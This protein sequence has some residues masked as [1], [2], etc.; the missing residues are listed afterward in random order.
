M[1]TTTYICDICK[2]SVSSDDLISFE[3]ALI[4]SVAFSDSRNLSYSNK[5]VHKDI[6]KG[7]LEKFGFDITKHEN[8]EDRE[9][10]QSK[11]AKTLESK[12]VDLLEDL[13]VAFVE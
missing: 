13:G 9:S 8:R 7:C 2:Q 12:F 1:K 10:M 6:C 3:A 11:N 5:S 4:G